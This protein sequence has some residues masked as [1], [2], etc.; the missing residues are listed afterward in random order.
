[1]AGGIV[2]LGK[3][4][5]NFVLHRPLQNLFVLVYSP[6]SCVLTENVSLEPESAMV[7]DIVPIMKTRDHS[8][9][10]YPRC[11]RHPRLA[12]LEN[13]HVLLTNSAFHK[14]K[15]AMVIVTAPY[16]KTKATFVRSDQHLP[17][18]RF[19]EPTISCVPVDV[20]S[21]KAECVMVSETALMVKMREHSANLCLL[22]PLR[23]RLATQA[24]LHV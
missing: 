1:M 3:M 19:A 6:S 22:S 21:R 16:P 18:H 2:F 23:P 17:Q 5:G 11:L 12:T 7:L 24:N 14:I 9:D 20:A 13:S 10:H 4:K 8:V 15:Y